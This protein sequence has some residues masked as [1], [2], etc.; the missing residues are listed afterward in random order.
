M[1]LNTEDIK[2]IA[3]LARLKLSDTEIS[4]YRRDFAGILEYVDQLRGLKF[5]AAKK[6]PSRARTRLRADRV[7]AWAEDERNNSLDQA[8]QRQSGQL[9]TKR[10]L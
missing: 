9:K 8:P 7:A 4:Q 6:I 2:K 3:A 10:I 1:A 5:S